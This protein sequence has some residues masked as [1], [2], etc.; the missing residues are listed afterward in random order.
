[1][2]AVDWRDGAA[3]R[4]INAAIHDHSCTQPAIGMNQNPF[5]KPS[6]PEPRPEFDPFAAEPRSQKT[7]FLEFAAL[8][9]VLGGF[10]GY[11]IYLEAQQSPLLLTSSPKRTPTPTRS[12][13]RRPSPGSTAELPSPTVSGLAIPPSPIV[14]TNS[15]TKPALNPTDEIYQRSPRTGI[16]YASNALLSTSRREIVGGG[17][18]YCI[19]LINGS[20]PQVG[21]PKQV[22]VSSL[23]F[24]NDGIYIDATDEK[25][26]FD[27]T[28]TEI[29]DRLG[30]WQLLE[31][32]EDRA[33]AM[34]DCLATAE[35]F[36]QQVPTAP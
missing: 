17:D 35:P 33:G 25:L 4:L 14:R 30:T 26:G 21:T 19:K 2:G 28:Y 23:S 18:R 9:A 12:P 29:T 31:T 6:E 24:R 34:G 1:M 5:G 32:K 27:R 7:F 3:G 8:L 20:V 11:W 16:Y 10:L 36:I 15:T 13:T 22:I